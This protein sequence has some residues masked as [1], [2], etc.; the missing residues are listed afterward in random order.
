MVID[1]NSGKVQT[2]AAN[3]FAVDRSNTAI[4]PSASIKQIVD[5]YKTLVQPIANRIIGSITA[6]L[7]RTNNAAGESAMGDIIADAQLVATKD[8]GFGDAAIAF[9]NPGGVRADLSYASST[10]GEGDGNVTFGEAFTVQPFGNSLVTMTLTGAQIETLLEQ[11]FTGCTNGQAF[12]RILSA[13][14]GFSYMWSASGAACDKVDP[15]SIMLNGVAVDPEASYRVTVNSFLADGGDLFTVLIQG[16]NRL[17][18]AQDSDALEAY[19][20]ANSPLAPGASDRIQLL[21]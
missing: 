12:N 1:A 8:P 4:T 7:S 16:T 17:G 5:N 15:N 14:E 10:A 9:M 6:T 13:S 3:N 2:V 11:Q 19:F 21:P 18:G 20:T